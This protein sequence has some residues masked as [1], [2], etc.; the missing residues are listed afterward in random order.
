MGRTTFRYP[1]MCGKTVL[2]SGVTRTKT[3][4]WRSLASGSALN[5]DVIEL[6]LV[7]V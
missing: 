6:V 5:L 3:V 1:V 2:F 4:G 7:A